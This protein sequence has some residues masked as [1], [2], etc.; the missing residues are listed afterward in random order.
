MQRSIGAAAAVLALT[1][2]LAAADDPADKAAERKKAAEAAW[3]ETGVGDFSTLETDHLLIYAPK[4]LEKRL[5]EL[6]A[7]LEKQLSQA[8]S[9]LGYDEKTEPLPAK[10][11]VYLFSQREQ[12][13]AFVRR[14]DK[15]RLDSDDAASFNAEDDALH[16]AAGPARLKSDLGP[17]GEAA[18][19]LAA[20]L[21]ARKA[22]LKTILPGWLTEGFGRATYHRTVGGS[23]AAG[24]KREAA[25]WAARGSAKDI[26]NGNIDAEKASALQGSLAE[27]FAYGP[28]APKFADFLKG[29]APDDNTAQQTTEKALTSIG[30]NAD[31]VDQSWRAW[32]LTK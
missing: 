26:W 5:K 23:K 25:A 14:V 18:E 4:D 32:A 22:G 20:L 12:F 27:Y 28:G 2:A 11:A 21:L 29:F 6:G 13:S 24:D 16:V 17:E 1:A 10:A 19:Q 9:A 31:R 8:K 30:Q 7:L 3:T 15:Q